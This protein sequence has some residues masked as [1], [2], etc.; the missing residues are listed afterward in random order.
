MATTQRRLEGYR[1]AL[2]AAGVDVDDDLI[3][4][5]IHAEADASAAVAALGRSPTRRPR[6]SLP[7]RP[8]R[9]PWSRFC[10]HR[11]RNRSRSSGS[12]TSRSRP[13]CSRR[14]P[15]ST[16]IRTT[17][18]RSPPPGCSPVPTSPVNACA[19][20]RPCLSAWSCGARVGRTDES[21]R[22][23]V[24]R[25]L[26]TPKTGSEPPPVVDCLWYQPTVTGRPRGTAEPAV[27]ADGE[28]PVRQSHARSTSGP[29]EDLPRVRNVAV[30]LPVELLERFRRTA[31]S[32]EMTY[33][34]LL[35]EAAA[36]HLADRGWNRDRVARRRR[37]AAGAGRSDGP[38]PGL[39]GGADR[40]LQG[41]AG[42][43]AGP[44][45][46][47][48]RSPSP[49]AG[50]AWL[51]S[52][53]CGTRQLCS[54]R[55]PR[56]RGPTGCWTGSGLPSSSCS[57]LPVPML[58]ARVWVAGGGPDLTDPAGLILDVDAT[59]L[60]AHRQARR[61]PDVQARLRVPSFAGLPRPPRRIRRRSP[62]RD[63]APG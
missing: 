16:R 62:G 2:S 12:V 47:T 14:S 42:A 35:V 58:G 22:R 27:A 51:T 1:A 4:T 48:L 52:P 53:G 34:D 49:T 11:R 59:L 61:H 28:A 25:P 9:L 56:T 60:S 32:R 24:P 46:P 38:D 6:C 26:Q 30:Y 15:S 7:T 31:R 57:G 44:G 50:T 33:A 10:R 37:P 63:P 19:A 3:C 8:A 54:V 13:R 20:A 23:P 17:S 29:A 55:S 18:G 40:H 21:V 36:A 43:P 41:P 39:D 45:A 5:G